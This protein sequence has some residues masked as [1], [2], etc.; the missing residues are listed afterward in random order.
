MEQEG[1]DKVRHGNGRVVCDT[2]N[3]PQVIEDPGAI[4][5]TGKAADTV[6]QD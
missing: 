6:F 2:G 1:V 5:A 4:L 3:L